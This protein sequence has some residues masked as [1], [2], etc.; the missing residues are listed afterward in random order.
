MSL[1]ILP[2]YVSSTW[3]DLEPERK[4]VEQA[5]QRLR[6]TKFVGMEYFGSRDETTRRASL[7]EVD[8][9]AERGTRGVYV[10]IFAARYGSGITEAEYRRARELGLPCFIYFKADAT[11]PGDS[12]EK[13]TAKAAKLDALKQELRA[14]HIIGP[15]FTSP[16]NL[17]A[18]LTADL[19]RWLF[20]NYL[21][22]KLQGALGGEVSREEA[23]ALLGA[24]KDLSALNRDLVARLQGA[25]FFAPPI[26][27]LHQLRAA[28][29]DFVGREKEIADL[30]ATLRGGGS[31]AISSVSHAGGISGMG[32]IGKTELAFYVANELRDVYPDA[33]LVL[34]MR[35]TDDAPRAPADALAAC[36]RAFLGLEQRLPDDTEQLTQLYRSTLEGK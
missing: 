31:A 5:V 1:T 20:D 15:D 24:V 6:E 18:K 4:A 7:D 9:A 28:V 32:G 19:Y 27:T 34:D 33:Q 25:G 36:I 2:V 8:R 13:E 29:G 3:L 16:D 30:L 10:G 23:Q 35:G 22:P 12:R 11:I 14:N 21:T 17:A 26:P